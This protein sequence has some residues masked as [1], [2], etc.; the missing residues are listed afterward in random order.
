MGDNKFGLVCPDV[1]HCYS[2][3]IAEQ[4]I[5]MTCLSVCPLSCLRNYIPDLSMRDT[6]IRGS[7]ILWRRSDML[8]TSGFMDDVIFAHKPM[9]FDVMFVHKE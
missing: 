3:P 8:C 4:S 7:V 5:V 1:L 6:Y 9:R 2:S